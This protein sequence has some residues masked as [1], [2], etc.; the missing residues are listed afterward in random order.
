[1]GTGGFSVDGAGSKPSARRIS[2][3]VSVV[4]VKLDS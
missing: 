3:S 4:S 1:L 2:T